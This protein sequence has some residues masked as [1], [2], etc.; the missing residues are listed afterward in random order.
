MN[1]FIHHI[2]EY[3]KGLRRL[4]LFTGNS[5]DRNLILDK[6]EKHGINY[7]IKDV[8]DKKINVFF[9]SEDCINVLLSFK[10]LE[11][12]KLSDYEDFILGIML[13]YDVLLQCERYIK[14][15]K[16]KERSELC[17]LYIANR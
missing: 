9:G 2:Y 16:I 10:S 13:G 12:D 5:K 6:L 11:L 7:I 4:V 8:S 14:R 15:V 17:R 3:K 1:V